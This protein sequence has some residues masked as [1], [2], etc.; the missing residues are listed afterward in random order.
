MPFVSRSRAVAKETQ[1]MDQCYIQARCAAGTTGMTQHNEHSRRS[2][3]TPITA[4][5][6]TCN[7]RQSHEWAIGR[8]SR[9]TIPPEF[10]VG[11][12]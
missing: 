12:R 2:Q 7:S 4:L 10:G 9:G 5:S 6:P 11:G 8:R 1:A 3:Q